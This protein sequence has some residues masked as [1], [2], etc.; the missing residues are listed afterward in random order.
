[1]SQPD[2][3]Q[4]FAT[5]LEKELATLESDSSATK[6]WEEIREI[7]HRVAMATFGK[8]TSKSQDWFDAKATEITPII[9]AKR[10]ILAA[11]KALPSEQ[12]LPD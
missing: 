3:V 11:Y 8:K 10:L 5:N 1:M 2:L 9:E 6:T 4:L 7:I 12:N